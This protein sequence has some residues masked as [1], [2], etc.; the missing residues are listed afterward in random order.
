MSRAPHGTRAGYRS[1]C[2]CLP[3]KAAHAAYHRGWYRSTTQGK[4]LL[5]ARVSAVA[6]IRALEREGLSW[7]MMARQIGLTRIR[8]HW[9]TR[10]TAARLKRLAEA[11]LLSEAK[12]AKE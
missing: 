7:R 6:V 4:L 1:G 5:G 3:C 8:H 9:V 11:H 12:E 2:R 10:R